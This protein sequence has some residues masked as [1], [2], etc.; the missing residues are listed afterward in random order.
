MSVT[1][2]KWRRENTFSFVENRQQ[3]IGGTLN[4]KVGSVPAKPTL[5]DN[6]DKRRRH[7]SYI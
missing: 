2:Y 1:L 3:Y 5:A 4:D 7:K 6:T